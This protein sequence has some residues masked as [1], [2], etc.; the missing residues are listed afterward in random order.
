[1]TSTRLA[2]V[3]TLTIG[4]VAAAVCLLGVPVQAAPGDLDPSFGE[5]GKVTTDVGPGSEMAAAI[6]I[7]ADG[8]IVVAGR[9]GPFSDFVLARYNTDGNLDPSFGIGGQVTTDFGGNN[10]AASGVAIQADGKIVAAGSAAP[11]SSCCQFA[12]ARY[13][14]DGS[15]DP[16]FGTGGQV[17]TDFGG[18]DEASGVAIQAD[19]KIVVAGRGGPSSDFALARYNA[20]GTLDPSFGTG[21]QVTTDFGGFGDAANGVAIQTDGKIVAAGTG[22]ALAR[23]NTDGS[24]DPSF[25]TG[26]QV[27]TRGGDDAFGIAI[28]SDG[29]IVAAGFISFDFNQDFALARYNVDG[30]LDGMVTTDFGDRSGD[31]AEAVAIQADGKIVAAGGAG[32]C[33]PPCKFA[34][35]RYLT[36]PPVSPLTVVTEGSGTGMVISVPPGINCGTDCSE[37]YP[38]G[39]QVMLMATAAEGSVFA[40][41][42]R[43]GCSGTGTC[44]I[45]VNADIAIAAIFSLISPITIPDVGPATPYPSS[46]TVSGLTGIVSKVTV[47][48][49]DAS[50]TFVSDLDILLV[51]PGGQSVVLASGVGGDAA[52]SNLTVTFDDAGAPGTFPPTSLFPDIFFFP[53]APLPPYG[54]ALAVFEGTTPNGTWNLFVQDSVPFD[55]GLIEGGWSLTITTTEGRAR[56]IAP[57]DGSHLPV[58][59]AVTFAWTGLPGVARYGFEFTGP[60]GQFLNPNGPTP[61]PVNGFG[62]AGGGFL[63][64]GTSFTLVIDPSIPLATYQVRVIGVSRDGRPIGIFSDAL[65]ITVGGGGS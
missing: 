5:G 22:F 20:D 44:T 38:V 42:N 64:E 28:Q 49:R 16:S 23:Y 24:L 11:E 13:N 21:G 45:I 4:F 55:S 60:N 50:H 25:G 34:L 27:T 12:L 18:L 56:M 37:I 29:K 10:D 63:V 1:M 32:P 62:G 52:I 40:G 57:A 6:A 3:V 15:L 2:L 14:T 9:G 65:A 48:L 26:G 58:G 19:G 61:D 36:L 51:G 33:S 54:S 47:T 46:I 31:V 35:A 53:P 59:T 8:K 39:T 43:G 41:W 30:S 7:Q 17:T